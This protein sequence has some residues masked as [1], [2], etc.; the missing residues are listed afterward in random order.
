MVTGTKALIKA[1]L[2][3]TRICN[4]LSILSFVLITSSLLGAGLGYRYISSDKFKDKVMDRIISD[5]QK[6]LPDVLNKTLPNMTSPSIPIKKPDMKLT[7]E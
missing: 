5:V 3:F 4:Y 2:M 1:S 7:K 6:I